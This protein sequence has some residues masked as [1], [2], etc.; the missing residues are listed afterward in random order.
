MFTA[1]KV[2]YGLFKDDRLTTNSNR[3][4]LIFSHHSNF[5]VEDIADINK[6]MA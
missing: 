3:V 6:E 1:R 4:E 5:R 2:S